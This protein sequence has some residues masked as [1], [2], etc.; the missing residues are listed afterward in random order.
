MLEIAPPRFGLI[1]HRGAQDFYPEN[2]IESCLAALDFG[3]TWIEIDLQLTACGHWVVFHDP[4]LERTSN[5]EG[6]VCHQ[7]LAALSKLRVDGTY[8]IPTLPTLLQAIT[9]YPVTINLELKVTPA[10]HTDALKA[11]QHTIDTWPLAQLPYFSSFDH[12][13]LDAIR[14]RWPHLPI[15]YLTDHPD[16]SLIEKVRVMPNTSLNCHAITLSPAIVQTLSKHISILAYTVNDIA[17]AHALLEAGVFGIFT[18]ETKM[19]SK[20]L[21]YFGVL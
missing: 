17:F 13:I 15:G 14:L 5:G 8:A 16:A 19:L 10:Q 21:A 1:G 20:S 3:L 11:I 7:D 6:L 18:D 12:V 2:T 4:T 9:P